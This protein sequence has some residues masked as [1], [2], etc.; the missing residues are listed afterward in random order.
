MVTY[1]QIIHYKWPKN[2]WKIDEDDYSTF[3]W[4]PSNIDSKPTE[5]EIIE[6]KDEADIFYQWKDVR[7]ERD[8]LLRN[9]DWTQL[10]DAPKKNKAKWKKYRQDL[11]E[12]PQFFED[13]DFVIWPDKPE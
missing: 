12:V 2:S 7:N 11:R 4:M 8:K 6:A 1:A 13:P 3:S 9:S 5:K 10:A